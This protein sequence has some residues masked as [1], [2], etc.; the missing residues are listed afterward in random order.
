MKFGKLIRF[1]KFERQ[2]QLSLLCAAV[3]LGLFMFQ[4]R[5]LKKLE[6][7]LKKVRAE[8]QLVLKIDDMRKTIASK[9]IKPVGKAVVKQKEKLMLQGTV[10]KGKLYHALING[11]IY[12][13]GDIV[14]DYRVIDIHKN[15]VVLENKLTKE[16]HLLKISEAL[17]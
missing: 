7:R 17:R 10:L 3:L 8:K 14:G 1:I 12:K 9:K 6:V 2:L 4:C 15:S 13:K 11:L 16:F 5:A